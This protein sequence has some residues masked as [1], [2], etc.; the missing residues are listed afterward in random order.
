MKQYRAFAPLALLLVLVLLVSG[1]SAGQQVTA[2]QI[3]AK[4]R[5]TAKTTQTSQG[6]VDLN[7]A[8]NKDGLKAMAQTLMPTGTGTGATQDKDPIA[9][10]PDTA[11]ATIKVWKQS[12]DKA[13]VELAQSSLPAVGGTTAVYDGQKFYAFV[14]ANNTFY[15]GTPDKMDQVPDAYKSLLQSGDLQKEIDKIIDAAD[16]KVAGSEKVAGIDTYKLEITPKADAAQKLDLP[17]AVQSQV[18]L[19]IKDAHITLWVDKDRW[20]PL[21]FTLD[22]P[23]LGTF[24][25]TVTQ[26][27]LNKPID[28]SQFTLQAPKDA[29]SVDLDTVKSQMEPKAVTIQQARDA[30][31]KEGWKL[32]EPG[33]T[34]GNATLVGANQVSTAKG[35][36]F[37]LNY[38]SAGSSFSIVESKSQYDKPLGDGTSGKPDISIAKDVTVR[39][40]TGKVFSPGDGSYTV[41]AWQE[42]GSNAFMSVYGKLSQDEALKIAEGLK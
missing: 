36:A 6:V 27:D 39:G 30:A 13:R 5:D 16:T 3:I 32:L 10:L 29:K 14:P 40:V 24:T 15:T 19:I 18:G 25:Y 4:M 41:L 22:H 42:K 8:L 34:P 1:C 31:T 37:I 21:K 38:S 23:N 17:Q 20:I 12:P 9:Q 7:I 2:D 28:A 35:A 11:S 33:Y 26:M